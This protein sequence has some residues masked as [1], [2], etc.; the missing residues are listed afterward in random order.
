MELGI[1][2]A[3]S[4]T[5]VYRVLN[6]RSQTANS[7]Y[8]VIPP[9][10]NADFVAEMEDVL[11]VYTR[12][13]GSVRPLVFLDETSKHLL[14][15]GT[16]LDA[17]LAGYRRSVSVARNRQNGALPRCISPFEPH[18]STSLRRSYRTVA[19]HRRTARPLRQLTTR[20]V[21]TSSRHGPAYRTSM[22]L[23]SHRVRKTTVIC[24]RWAVTSCRADSTAT[25]TP[26]PR[27]LL[28]L[29]LLRIRPTERDGL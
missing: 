27:Q 18:I 8:W 11:D 6:K 9:K 22:K 5:A 14:A 20:C 26:V 2:E 25:K 10:A 15:F 24:A 21:R 3:A 12:P 28:N 19:L 17:I 29:G 13:Y 23:Q 4:D 7:R 16:R 1:V